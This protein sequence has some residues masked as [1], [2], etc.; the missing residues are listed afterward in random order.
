M[1]RDIR[2]LTGAQNEYAAEL[3]RRWGGFA[4]YVFQVEG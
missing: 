4:S 2:E 1:V 3:R